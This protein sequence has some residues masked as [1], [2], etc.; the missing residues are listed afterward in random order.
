M[1]R[2]A[3]GVDTA[4]GPWDEEVDLLVVG[5]GA[6]GMTAAAVAAHEGLRVLVCEKLAQVGGTTATSGG[7]V[8]APASTASARAGLPDDAQAARAYLYAD[9][10]LQGPDT[11]VEAFI[12]ASPRAIDYL[13]AHT[14]LKFDVPR[15]NPAYHDQP[16]AS[17]GGRTL[18]PAPFDGRLLGADF[19]R[20]RAPR[21]TLV[22]LGG[23][24]V[25]RREV[26]LLLKPWGS[27]QAAAFTARTLG[28][29]FM[30]RLRYRRGTRLLLG[31]ALVARL[32]YSLRQLGVALR[33]ETSLE[34]LETEAGRVVGASVL[35][36]G[37]RR[38]IRARRGVVLAT[39]GYAGSPQWR[40]RLGADFPVEYSLAF[41]DSTG[42]A[43][44]AAT[45]VGAALDERHDSPMFWAPVSVMRETGGREK[46]W[47][48]GVLDRAKPGLIAVDDQGR[49][50][51]NEANS[52]HDFVRDMYRAGMA[53]AHLLCDAAFLK[54]YGLGLVQ[55]IFP[56]YRRYLAS[57][58]LKRGATLAE[59]ARALGID[60]AGLQATVAAFN[61]SARHGQ[62]PA[63]GRGS[64]ALNRHNGD[65]TH[66][67]SPCVAPV[68]AAPFYAVT[69]YPGILGT[70]AGLRADV[71]GRV[72]RADGS[73][74]PG[75]YACGNDMASMMR[76]RYP[77]PGIT[78]GPALVFG[79]RVGMHAA[80][81]A[82]QE[83]QALAPSPVPPSSA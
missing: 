75:L 34:A 69:V 2:I 79:W 60:A 42:Q 35:Q 14:A 31:N 46:V 3:A 62:D 78:L 17:A 65:A 64:T 11:F 30:D 50:F 36:H 22:V 80:C 8:F 5:A 26:A 13:E 29:Y 68:E 47:M 74:I 37:Q 66:A 54:R 52:Y 48:H 67:V 18:L 10:G 41:E 76:G 28:R 45:A 32:L 12:A 40:Q 19:D 20:V 81:A 23:M 6:A 49:R 56:S 55:P 77:G 24:M 71:D 16:G 15:P 27:W 57:G 38:R 33:T 83:S 72:Q 39:G 59:L 1:S 21:D 61:A 7:M 25:A 53:R 63:F 73:V 82:A 43:F 70:S 58:Y 51:A 4:C 44:D 9:L